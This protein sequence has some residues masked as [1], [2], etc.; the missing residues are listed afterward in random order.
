MNNPSYPKRSRFVTCE[1]GSRFRRPILHKDGTISFSYFDRLN[2]KRFWVSR[3]DFIYSS[4]LHDLPKIESERV[5]KSG[6][7]VVFDHE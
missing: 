3:Q 6:I 5:T 2:Q 4:S 1:D 7:E